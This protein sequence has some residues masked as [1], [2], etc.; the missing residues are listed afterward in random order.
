MGTIRGRAPAGK[1]RSTGDWGL[2]ESRTRK[3]HVFRPD[4]RKRRDLGPWESPGTGGEPENWI[5]KRFEKPVNLMK[6]QNLQ[7][8]G[9]RLR[10]R[11]L[12]TLAYRL[13]FA[14]TYAH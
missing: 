5:L 9:K 7:G 2:R 8:H 6:R 12:S 14:R 4:D 1:R 3:L 10:G 11:P 13:R